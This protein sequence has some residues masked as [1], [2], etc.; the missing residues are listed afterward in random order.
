MRTIKCLHT[1]CCDRVTCFSTQKDIEWME[2]CCLFS[3][4]EEGGEIEIERKKLGNCNLNLPQSFTQYCV[5]AE[6][7][8]MVNTIRAVLNFDGGHGHWCHVYKIT[9]CVDGTSSL[10]YKKNSIS[11]GS[12]FFSAHFIKNKCLPTS[13]SL[14]WNA[15]N[16]KWKWKVFVSFKLCIDFVLMYK[17]MKQHQSRT[18]LVSSSHSNFSSHKLKLQYMYNWMEKSCSNF[19]EMTINL[20]CLFFFWGELFL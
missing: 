7:T 16:L 12:R 4:D 10:N 3:R 15:N 20:F 6:C 11:F 1:V 5:F 19:M 2:S 9:Q 13:I 18:L 8:K 14:F 17:I